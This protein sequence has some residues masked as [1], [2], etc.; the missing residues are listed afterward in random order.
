MQ[1]AYKFVYRVHYCS[2]ANSQCHW[3]SFG[4]AR[5]AQGIRRDVVLWHLIGDLRIHHLIAMLIAL[6]PVITYFASA[7]MLPGPS[8]QD[9]SSVALVCMLYFK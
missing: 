7:L 6:P 9:G 4:L 3:F 2:Y 1:R 8:L 5:L